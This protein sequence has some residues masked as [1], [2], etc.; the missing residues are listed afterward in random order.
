MQFGRG[1]YGKS[2]TVLAPPE[3]PQT[4][5]N[6]IAAA[7]SNTWLKVN[8][9]L[10]SDVW[11]ISDYRP[12]Y[13]GGVSNVYPLLQAWS[14][15]A[16]DDVNYRAILWGGGH[17]NTNDNSVYM[18][19]AYTQN[20]VLAFYPAQV[21]ATPGSAGMGIETID[22]PSTPQSSHT[23]D[24][25]HWLPKLQRFVTFGGA[26]SSSGG[27]FIIRGS[28]DRPVGCFMLD[29]AQAGTGKVAGTTGSNVKRNTTVGVNLTGANAWSKRDWWLD[30]AD[31]NGILSSLGSSARTNSVAAYREENGHD[32]IYYKAGAG[33]LYRFEFV[34]G[35]YLNDILSRVGQ[36]W[37]TR[38]GPQ[39][40]ALDTST[41]RFVNMIDSNFPFTY[42]DLNSAGPFNQDQNVA[43][44]SLTGADASEF[45]T[46]MEA[47][48]TF[49][50][51][52]DE[53]RSRLVAWQRGGRVYAINSS[54][55]A[56]TKLSDDSLGTRPL[57]SSEYASS[58][59][60]DTGVNGKWRRSAKL[61][62]YIG[63]QKITDGNIW[64]FKPSS[65]V[66]P[67]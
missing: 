47:S 29:M 24:T 63:I 18:W 36:A 15:F 43:A 65:W 26:A 3:Y 41:N 4:L 55:W 64:I 25:Q 14:S 34:D 7:G 16:W 33:H 50:L 10:F 5:L 21:Q 44:A 2:R 20:W 13:S 59:Q 67:R 39:G 12:D 56:V 38:D 35:N 60:E 32:V 53:R 54:T 51:E 57:T 46:Q 1:N 19:D 49:S 17:A 61:D 8:T 40:G 11:P 48:A 58:G 23:Y 22:W 28:P 31:P 62:C 45:L 9:N 52:Y 42:W 27:M 66:D 37:T 6:L 30:H